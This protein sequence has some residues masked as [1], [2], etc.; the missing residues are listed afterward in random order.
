MI[1]NHRLHL[2]NNQIM[3]HLI[4]AID[5]NWSKC[6]RGFIIDH[7]TSLYLIIFQSPAQAPRE[8]EHTQTVPVHYPKSIYEFR[9]KVQI[10]YSLSAIYSLVLSSFP[11]FLCIP[12]NIIDALKYLKRLEI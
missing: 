9:H 5:H 3:P 10:Q 4:Q 7:D 1:A 11:A 6:G 2:I 8:T 12:N